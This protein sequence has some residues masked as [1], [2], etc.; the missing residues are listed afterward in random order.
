MNI[1]KAQ[2]YWSLIAR[3]P[4]SQANQDLIDQA[5]EYAISV[6]SWPGDEI[7][8]VD[9]RKNFIH[10]R[11][12]VRSTGQAM[13]RS[14]VS[15]SLE[16]REGDEAG[17]DAMLD[18]DRFL[19][20]NSH[21]CRLEMFKVPFLGEAIAKL[22]FEKTRR[23]G[24]LF[25]DKLLAADIPDELDTLLNLVGI[26]QLGGTNSPPDIVDPS[27]DA[28]RGPP[29]GLIAFAC[30]HICHALEQIKEPNKR[31]DFA[32]GRYDDLW[33]HY[34]RELATHPHLGMLRS[35]ILDSIKEEYGLQYRR[36]G[37]PLGTDYAW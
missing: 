17:V 35:S 30:I 5:K 23:V 3:A 27:P 36:R 37:A 2:L 8:S 18:R 1:M 29:L 24:V 22:L 25:I 7:V 15:R 34:V 20:P 10:S 13:I 12:Q 4:F 32:E 26:P 16:L 6:T 9:F 11:S 21:M 31:I 28:L 33:A 14:L 19:Y